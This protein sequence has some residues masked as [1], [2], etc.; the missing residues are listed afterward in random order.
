M[1]ALCAFHALIPHLLLPTALAIQRQKNDGPIGF[2]VTPVVFACIVILPLITANNWLILIP[3]VIV[4]AAINMIIIVVKGNTFGARTSLFVINFIVCA[5][6][7]ANDAWFD[8]FNAMTE[9]FVRG[10]VA[11]NVLAR[12]I[13]P[14]SFSNAL[15]TMAG[16]ILVSIELNNPIALI[17]KRLQVMPKPAET[18]T[19]GSRGE[20]GRGRVIGYLERSLVFLLVITGNLGAIGLVLAAKAF[21]RFR[22]LDDRDFAEYV[23]IGTL[24]S[25]GTTVL[26]GI[27]MTGLLV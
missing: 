12:S 10:A 6:V 4:V 21:A 17:L 19:A 20:P 5:M 26:V 23:L 24:L 14:A 13:S 7:Y 9:N 8:G 25:I 15:V 27:M 1:I 2:A 11:V 22:Q 16:L 18:V 3:A